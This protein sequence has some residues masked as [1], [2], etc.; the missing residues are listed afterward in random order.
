MRRRRFILALLWTCWL[1]IAGALA[2]SI[3]CIN[4]VPADAGYECTARLVVHSWQKPPRDAEVNRLQQELVATQL[5]LLNSPSLR[6][7]TRDRLVSKHQLKD[8]GGVEIET[9]AREGII[10]LRTRGTDSQLIRAYLEE[11]M[12]A[13]LVQHKKMVEVENTPRVVPLIEGLLKSQARIKELEEHLRTLESAGSDAQRIT[14]AKQERAELMG[15]SQ[16][17]QD[18]LEAVDTQIERERDP[19]AILERPG[20]PIAAK[21]PFLVAIAL[22]GVTGCVAGLFLMLLVAALIS[23]TAPVGERIAPG[24]ARLP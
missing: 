15:R 8:N 17:L 19:I 11:W 13:Y 7:Q 5:E 2:G 23:F 18:D 3:W 4:H 21:R 22:G 20:N 24:G 16:R 10:T 6:V 9:D 14:E 1:P 12:D